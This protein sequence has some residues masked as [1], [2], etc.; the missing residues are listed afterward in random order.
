MQSGIATQTRQELDTSL[1][2]FGLG[3]GPYHT[4]HREGTIENPQMTAGYVR[5]LAP[6][7]LDQQRA[8]GAKDL[9]VG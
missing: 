8:F 1:P 2:R 5:R 4:P 3:Q 9:A 6:Q 7:Q